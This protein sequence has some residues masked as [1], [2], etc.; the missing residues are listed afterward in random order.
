[1]TFPEVTTKYEVW[2]EHTKGGQDIRVH[3][4]SEEASARDALAEANAE[5]T[6]FTF[7]L[8]RCDS[9]RERLSE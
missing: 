7:Y 8:V 4:P 9:I 5:N 3:G 1:M 6:R 2:R